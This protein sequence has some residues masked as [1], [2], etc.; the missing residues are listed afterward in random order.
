MYYA[1]SDDVKSPVLKSNMFSLSG[2]NFFDSIVRSINLG[3][4][5]STSFPIQIPNVFLLNFYFLLYINHRRSKC[6]CF[7]IAA[8]CLFVKD[9][10]WF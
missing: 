5:I 4:E 2:S 7:A 8:G 9:I 1:S 3:N 6:T 10:F